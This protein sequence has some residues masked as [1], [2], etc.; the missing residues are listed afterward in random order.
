[1]SRSVGTISRGIRTPI[2]NEGDDLIQTLPEIIIAAAKEN[3][4]DLYDQDVLAI[5]ESIVARA[6]GNYT[7][8]FDICDDLTKQLDG[9]TTIGLTF[10]I[11]SRNRFSI[12][13]KGI[14]LAVDEV[15]LQLTYPA[16]EVG[17][18]LFSPHLLA[19]SNINPWTDVLSEKEFYRHF[20][21]SKHRFT[22]IDYIQCYRQI[23]EEQGAKCT[24]IFA[25]DI[26]EIL[27]HTKTVLTCDIHSRQQ[28]KNILKES[29]SDLV[30]GLDDLL[31]TPQ[32]G[33]G[34]NPDYGLLGS[35]KADDEREI[36][37]ASCRERV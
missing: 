32:E 17:N 19:Y 4:F 31:N 14:A 26:R 20:G 21:E 24:I 18:E 3:N 16:D 33:R 35:N 37:R 29:G 8:I 1:M 28:S 22:G 30:L 5:T 13:L 15:V 25:N 12:L 27:K 9:R 2:F 7:T 11:L 36:G 6:Q 10:P 23:I 34:Y